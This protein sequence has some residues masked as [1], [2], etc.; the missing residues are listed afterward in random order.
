[1]VMPNPEEY[2]AIH[3]VSRI[4]RFLNNY[5]AEGTGTLILSEKAKNLIGPKLPQI[6]I[7]YSTATQLNLFGDYPNKSDIIPSAIF[8]GLF[9]IIAILHLIVFSI[10]YYRGHYFWLSLG[11]VFYAICRILGFAL[12][13]VWSHDLTDCKVGITSE[14]FLIIPTVLIASFNLVL[15]QRIFTWRH[16]VGGSRK[17]FW[18]LMWILYALVA[19]VVAM[20]IVTS[21]G[22]NIYLLSEANYSRYKKVV[23]STSILIIIY[24]LTAVGLILLAWLFKPTKKDENLYTYQPWWIESFAPFY[25]VKKN[26]PQIAALSFL[27]RNHN[28]RYAIRV[29]A[30][31]HNLHKTVKGLTNQR[32]DLT[33][34]VSL[35]IIGVTT[36]IILVSSIL[37]AVICFQGRMKYFTAP[38][39]KAP[40]MYVFWGG[41]EVGV[42]LLYIIG[43][44][45][46]RFYRPDR[47]PKDVRNIVTAEQSLYPSEIED[48]GDDQNVLDKESLDKHPQPYSG[49]TFSN[50]NNNNNHHHDDNDDNEFGFT[51]SDDKDVHTDLDG[52]EDFDFINGGSEKPKNNFPYPFKEKSETVSEFHF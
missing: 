28:H 19:G 36:L 6:L 35:M 11:W 45:D 8:I 24:S 2:T 10:N 7:D 40:V 43:R 47:L 15:A 3:G 31:T 27:K 39:G 44:V 21:G 23:M 50:N 49:K 1:M 13:I 29:I 52:N 38:V 37:R 42:N 32:G 20:T 34:N 25:F 17:I 41:L 5:P 9:S 26:E 22:L 14:V 16:P 4:L 12:R 30:A 33:H 48:E 46:L 18:T 51:D